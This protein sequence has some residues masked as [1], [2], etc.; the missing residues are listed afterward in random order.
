MESYGDHR[1]F[2]IDGVESRL[3][4]QKFVRN[5]SEYDKVSYIDYF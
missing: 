2:K 5:L 1:I 3:N 4:P